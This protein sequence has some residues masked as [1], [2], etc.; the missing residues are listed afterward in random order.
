MYQEDSKSNF[1]M[2]VFGMTQKQLWFLFGQRVL[3]ILLVSLLVSVLISIL[4]NTVVISQLKD[5]IF[6]V[7]KPSSSDPTFLLQDIKLI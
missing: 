3:M 4:I 7:I 2:K 5:I 6:G 1:L